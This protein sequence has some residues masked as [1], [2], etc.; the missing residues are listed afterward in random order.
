VKARDKKGSADAALI[1]ETMVYGVFN[2]LS[3]CTEG[4][5]LEQQALDHIRR[6]FFVPFHLEA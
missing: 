4:D 5:K 2:G 1:R 6:G 3:F